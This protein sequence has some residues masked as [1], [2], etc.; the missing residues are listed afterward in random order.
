MVDS[1]RTI[2]LGI[3]SVSWAQTQYSFISNNDTMQE[4]KLKDCHSAYSFSGLKFSGS[5]GPGFGAAISGSGV[6]GSDSGSNWEGSSARGWDFS[7]GATDISAG[8][9]Q[10]VLPNIS[11]KHRSDANKRL[12]VFI[13]FSS[14]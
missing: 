12:D 10:P 9:S 14:Y 4:F 3:V 2:N 5:S 6:T 7:S 11:S 13:G 1:V 8:S